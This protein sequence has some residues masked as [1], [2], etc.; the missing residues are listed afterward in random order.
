[1]PVWNSHRNTELSCTQEKFLKS[2]CM[3][4]IYPI[5]DS[6]YMRMEFDQLQGLFFLARCCLQPRASRFL[7]RIPSSC[8][9][10]VEKVSIHVDHA[11]RP[12]LVFIFTNV[13]LL[14]LNFV[15]VRL[16]P[17]TYELLIISIVTLFNQY[18]FE[19]L[20]NSMYLLAYLYQPLYLALHF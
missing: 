18:S 11:C 10:H 9:C 6:C 16:F 7:I 13:S 19:I 20:T 5:T 15:M 1:M 14:D 4:F 12:R 3:Y 2:S 8:P 17:V